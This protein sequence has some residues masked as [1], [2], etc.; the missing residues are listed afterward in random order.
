[1]IDGDGVALFVRDAEM[2][3]VLDALILLLGD[4]ETDGETDGVTLLDMEIEDEK[5]VEEEIDG[6]T[7]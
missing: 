1:M 3:G 7:L 6:V 4:A 2:D 5:L